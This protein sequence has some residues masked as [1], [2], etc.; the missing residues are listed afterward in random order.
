MQL[1]SI[2][3]EQFYVVMATHESGAFIHVAKD[4]SKAMGELYVSDS[5]GSQF[6]LSLPN[7]LYKV[8]DLGFIRYTVDDFYEVPSMR[9]VYI[10]TQVVQGEQC[11]ADDTIVMLSLSSPQC[12]LCRVEI[13]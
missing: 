13:V 5:S 9:G 12:T 4:R 2:K 6:S 1:P 11:N 8:V 3:P 10:T 7:H